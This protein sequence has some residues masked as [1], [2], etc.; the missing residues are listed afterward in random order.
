MHQ[1]GVKYQKPGQTEDSVWYIKMKGQEYILLKE[2][3][4]MDLFGLTEEEVRKH[5][6]KTLLKLWFDKIKGM[7]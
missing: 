2:Y 4:T 6:K 5:A 3:A 7:F 1:D